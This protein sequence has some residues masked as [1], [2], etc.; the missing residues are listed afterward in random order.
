MME[1]W[2]WWNKIDLKFKALLTV[3]VNSDQ[4][5][6][7]DPHSIHFSTILFFHWRP[8]CIHQNSEPGFFFEYNSGNRQQTTHNKQ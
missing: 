3:I 4:T 2:I 7:S 1:Y 5:P 6:F 8:I